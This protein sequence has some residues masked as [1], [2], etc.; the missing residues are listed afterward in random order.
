MRIIENF[1]SIYAI[2]MMLMTFTAVGSGDYLSAVLYALLAVI[3]VLDTG[4][5]NIRK[6]LRRLKKWSPEST[7]KTGRHRKAI[8][9]GI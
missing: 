7:Q 8:R 5:R 4:W 6:E 2:C 3:C 9:V 1:L